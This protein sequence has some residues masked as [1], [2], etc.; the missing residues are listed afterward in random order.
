MDEKNEKRGECLLKVSEGHVT[1]ACAVYR[2]C[3]LGPATKNIEWTA[4][5]AERYAQENAPQ[6]E[7]AGFARPSDQQ[8]MCLHTICLRGLITDVMVLPNCIVTSL[9][10]WTVWSNFVGE[11]LG[12]RGLLLLESLTWPSCDCS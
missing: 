5:K 7:V 8:R 3:L 6:T 11:G 4:L 1:S 12:S 9:D 2:R 10:A